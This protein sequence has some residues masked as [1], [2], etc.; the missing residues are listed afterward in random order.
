MLGEQTA[1]EIKIIMW[2]KT[3]REGNLMAPRFFA[4]LPSLKGNHVTQ[5]CC[6]MPS[7]LKQKN[8]ESISFMLGRHKRIKVRD[9][10]AREQRYL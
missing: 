9:Y 8:E 7:L 5:L 3:R 6:L 4:K 2:H 10:T 1:A